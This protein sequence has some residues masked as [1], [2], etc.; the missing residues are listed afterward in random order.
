[1]GCP[2]KSAADLSF[3][4]THAVCYCK[5][6]TVTVSNLQKQKSRGQVLATSAV[7]T[8][9]QSRF[10]SDSTIMGSFSV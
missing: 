4:A 5:P 7:S 8:R 9:S 3:T 2:R 6:A 1:M 10:D